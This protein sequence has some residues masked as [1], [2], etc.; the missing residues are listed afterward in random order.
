MLRAIMA[1]PGMRR[2]SADGDREPVRAGGARHIRSH[3]PPDEGH[4]LDPALDGRAV[5][6]RRR[7][8]IHDRRGRGPASV[9]VA[10]AYPDA[11]RTA[12]RDDQAVAGQRHHAVGAAVSVSFRGRRAELRQRA[13][14]TPSAAPIP[15][16]GSATRH[17]G[18]SMPCRC[19]RCATRSSHGSFMVRGEIVPIGTVTMTIMVSR[20]C[21]GPR[22]R[23][24]HHGTRRRGRAAFSQKLQRPDWRVME[25]ERTPARDHVAD[26]LLQGVKS[27]PAI[28]AG[29]G[30]N[31]R[32]APRRRPNLTVIFAVH[33][34]ATCSRSGTCDAAPTAISGSD[35]Y[36]QQ[37]TRSFP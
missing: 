21:S 31:C 23:K 4:P 37:P 8:G 19:C 16:C 26:G 11:T 10:S 30:A 32:S 1:Q 14:A 13:P 7:R 3:C 18:V 22:G 36:A 12:V 2:R 24:H 34:P 9:M 35:E 5:A 28:L 29:E 33:G 25:P 6:A 15:E 20:R 17:P 27:P